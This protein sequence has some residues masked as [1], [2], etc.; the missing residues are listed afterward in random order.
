[1]KLRLNSMRES[2][3]P[4]R[5]ILGQYANYVRSAVPLRNFLP[6]VTMS[7]TKGDFLIRT[8]E[9]WKDVESVLKLRYEVFL[10]EGL[11]LNFPLG[12]DV[13]RWDPLADHLMVIDQRNHQLIG[14]YRL[15]SSS[16]SNDFYSASEFELAPF[17]TKTLGGKLELSRACIKAEYRS[18]AAISLL[19][20]GIAAYANAVGAR[21][22]FGCAS[23]KT[24]DRGVADQLM[25]YFRQEGLFENKEGVFPL[26]NYRMPEA[27]PRTEPL[28]PLKVREA[29]PPLLGS[30]LRAGA[31]VLCEPALDRSFKC[32][33]FLTVLDFT[34]INAAFERRYLS[35]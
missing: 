34:N 23:I 5:T 27:T 25:D 8:A 28:A 21:Y 32:L 35:S 1:M 6:K 18:T 31:K 15:I 29:I 11:N 30:Y 20:R 10:R 33:D 7:I 3:R 9:S 19:W 24:M 26:P 14:T 2:S 16:F 4:L 12:M 13:D 17:L 22:L